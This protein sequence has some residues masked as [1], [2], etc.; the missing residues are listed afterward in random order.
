MSK[1]K[2]GLIE[3]MHLLC[4][5]PRIEKITEADSGEQMYLENRTIYVGAENGASAPLRY[6]TELLRASLWHVEWRWEKGENMCTFERAYNLV[7]AGLAE[8]AERR[9]EREQRAIVKNYDGITIRKQTILPD[10]PAHG[11]LVHDIEPDDLANLWKVHYTL[12]QKEYEVVVIHARSHLSE[13]EVVTKTDTTYA[14]ALLSLSEGFEPF[15]A[16]GFIEGRPETI[17]EVTK[18]G[19]VY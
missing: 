6:I 9:N 18:L 3:A 15:T 13:K 10:M 5:D 1:V 14:E 11:I 16:V 12:E 8:Y 7:D 17:L 4:N 19:D 2:Y